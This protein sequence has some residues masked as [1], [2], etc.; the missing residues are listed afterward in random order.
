[1]ASALLKYGFLTIATAIG[2]YAVFLGLLSNPRFQAHAVYLHKIQ[3]TW[4]K[5][6]NIPES[7]G[8]LRGQVTPFYIKVPDGGEVYAWHVLPVEAYRKNEAALIHQ[9]SGLSS[10][11]EESLSFRLLRDDPESILVIHMHGA[12]G[13]VGSGYR[14]PNYRALSAGDP[15][16]IHVLTFDYRGFGKSLGT[17]T[18]TGLIEDALAVVDWSINVARVPPSRILI[19][20]QSLGAA[21]NLAVAE[22][23][24]R[25]SPAIVFAGHVLVAPF[26]D[27]TSLVTT[28]K[29]AGTI[30]LL[31]PLAQF[32]FLFQYLKQFIEDKWASYARIANYI[33]VNEINK[34]PYQITIIHAKD[35]YDIP[36]QHTETL[37]WHAANATAREASLDYSKF[38]HLRQKG[39]S[40]LGSAGSE[41]LWTTDGGSLRE[42][43]L[44]TGLH[45][46]IMG[47]P[48]VSLAVMR[49]IHGHQS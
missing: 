22:R 44:E 17:P 26:V 32:P 7:F 16:R 27:T 41:F 21:V 38:Q 36:W 9:P 11:I 25:R 29:I 5:D 47:N 37:F 46:V 18:E 28:Y 33:Q 23:Y 6:L 40:M 1:M 39:R 8:F 3:M 12:A 20:G 15:S 14:V 45:D 42:E 13:T 48:V 49:L 35:D 19:F 2:L 34:R 31:S 4:F 30:P 10:D 24:A 43:I